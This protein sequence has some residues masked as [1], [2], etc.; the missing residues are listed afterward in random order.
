MNTA[1][2]CFV[3]VTLV[4]GLGVAGCFDHVAAPDGAVSGPSPIGVEPVERTFPPRATTPDRLLR[5]ISTA[6]EIHDDIGR[7]V[8]AAAFCD[9]S[10]RGMPA[11]RAFNDPAVLAAWAAETGRQPLNP[12]DFPVEIRFYEYLIHLYPG[13]TYTFT[14]SPDP[15]SPADIVDD[16]AGRATLHRGYHVMVTSQDRSV[17]RIIAVGY[18]D[19]ELIRTSGRWRVRTWNDRLDP[20]VGPHPADPEQRTMGWRRLDS[21]Q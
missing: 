3:L 9:S 1:R 20:S 12:T 8:Y 16:T 13:A 11:F 6:V 7:R 2:W 4:L 18:A 19:L 14:W 17:E 15:M 10:R 21:L 5:V